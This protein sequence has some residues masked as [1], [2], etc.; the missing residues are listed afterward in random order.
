MREERTGSVHV[1]S[2]EKT[3][4]RANHKPVQRGTQ[5]RRERV[6]LTTERKKPR[7]S[8]T[9]RESGCST[10]ETR[11][12][13]ELSK[14]MWLL[15]HRRPLRARGFRQTTRSSAASATNSTDSNGPAGR[16]NQLSGQPA[17]CGRHLHFQQ[18]LPTSDNTD[19]Q[20]TATLPT[21]QYRQ[22]RMPH[23]E[24]TCWDAG[25]A[26]LQ[27]SIT[28]SDSQLVSDAVP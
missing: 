17:E 26:M 2:R 25:R 19:S 4:R 27:D 18:Q 22:G 3:E 8:T 11:K 13:I 7:L 28:W 6:V 24:R 5:R 21:V 16:Q 10:S 9:R 20:P 1:P 23:H 12:N 15:R 14:Q